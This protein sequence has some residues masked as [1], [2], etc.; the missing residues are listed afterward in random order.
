[1]GIRIHKAMGYGLTDV[2]TPKGEFAP[3]GDPR[4]KLDAWEELRERN[5]SLSFKDAQAHV[6]AREEQIL[7]WGLAVNGRE[8]RTARTIMLGTRLAIREPL[9]KEGASSL[10]Y[11][12]EMGLANTML[13]VPWGR[14]DKWQ[15]YNDDLDWFDEVTT[16]ANGASRVDELKSPPYPYDRWVYKDGSGFA[17]REPIATR[18]EKCRAW[19]PASLICAVSFWE[20]CIVDMEAFLK[21]L[22][23]LLYVYWS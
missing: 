1:M 4:F 20:E 10:I 5:W 7:E 11:D 23:P 6:R 16:G 21:Q 14:Y 17:E 13:F 8:D 18:A 19:L 15:R 12:A 22:K 9:H 2:Q 3:E